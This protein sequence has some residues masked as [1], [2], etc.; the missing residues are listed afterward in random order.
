[1]AS[2]HDQ[3]SRGLSG[4][5][6]RLLAGVDDAIAKA[7]QLHSWWRSK[8]TDGSFADR[9]ELVRTFNKP[10]VGTGFFDTVQLT[11]GRLR[12]MGVDQA[13]HFTWPSPMISELHS[14]FR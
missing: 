7:R 12:V 8:A 3:S 6:L 5:D 9:F 14:S 1:M 4:E 13:M 2:D 10:D 11:T